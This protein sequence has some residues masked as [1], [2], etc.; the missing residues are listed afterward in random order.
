ML[1]IC[2]KRLPLIYQY[3]FVQ[4]NLCSDKSKMCSDKALMNLED[5]VNNTLTFV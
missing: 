4:S 3:I 2:R 5:G 1:K